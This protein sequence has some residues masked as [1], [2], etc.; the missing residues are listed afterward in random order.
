MVEKKKDVWDGLNVWKSY[1]FCY[2]LSSTRVTNRQTKSYLSIALI[3]AVSEWWFCFGHRRCFIWLLQSFCFCYFCCF[4]L[5]NVDTRLCICSL[6]LRKGL[7]GEVHWTESTATC[8]MGNL[9]S[10]FSLLFFFLFFNLDFSRL[11]ARCSFT[12]LVKLLCLYRK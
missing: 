1:I 2:I 11:V 5:K 9:P 7:L 12:D 4:V 6:R 10:C 3:L 8:I